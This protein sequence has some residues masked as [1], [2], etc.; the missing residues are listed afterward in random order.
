MI[1]ALLQKC[2][3][4]TQHKIQNI[5]YIHHIYGSLLMVRSSVAGPSSFVVVVVPELLTEGALQVSPRGVPLCPP[6][7]PPTHLLTHPRLSHREAV[8]LSLTTHTTCGRHKR[9]CDTSNFM[10]IW[11]LLL[12]LDNTVL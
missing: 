2:N 5:L 10:F 11:Q 9:R 4:I 12:N 3:V 7:H 1:Y 6:T 8:R